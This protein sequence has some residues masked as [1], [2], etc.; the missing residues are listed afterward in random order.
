M[1]LS[2]V[3]VA[4]LL[5]VLLSLCLGLNTS[6]AYSGTN[7][8]LIRSSIEV[9]LNVKGV[10]QVDFLLTGEQ[11]QLIN[12]NTF[13][14]LPITSPGSI[15]GEASWYCLAGVSACHYAHAGG[16]YA[17]AGPALRVGAWRNSQVDV[18][19]RSTCITVTLIDW[20]GCPNG[21]VI[22]LYG[23]AFAGLASRSIGVITVTVTPH[24]QQNAAASRSPQ[25]RHDRL[26]RLSLGGRD[27]LFQRRMAVRAGIR[28]TAT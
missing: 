9:N 26:P 20:C 12:A 1:A 5:A 3:A 19:R 23:D 21:R 11:K 18:C 10:R 27:D 28:P 22:D 8:V 4:V 2:R 7:P 6:L 24:T 13:P 14:L 25:P 17:A 15:R 16:M